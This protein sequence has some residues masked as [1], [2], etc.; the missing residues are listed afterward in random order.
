[1]ATFGA[2]LRP[3]GQLE[4]GVEPAEL[5]RALGEAETVGWLD[6]EAPTAEQIHELEGLFGFHPLALEDAQHADTR[7]KIEE[8]DTFLFVVT[9]GVDHGT[10]ASA[11]DLIP[12]YA[13]L[14]RRV[15]VTIHD[16][17]LRS[18]TTAME[19]L[20]KHPE[21]L[22]H[23]PDRLLHHLLDHIVDYF[24]PLLEELEDRV[25]RL[26]DR[27]FE[28]PDQ[29]LLQEIFQARRE[30][31]ALRRSIG[32]LR[33]VVTNLMSGVPYVDADL[34]PFFR[35]VYDHV[36][37]ILEELDA[38]RDLLAGLLES[39]LSQI[40]NRMNQVMKQLALV[41]TVGIPFTIVTSFFGMNFEIMPWLKEPW[42][43]LAAVITMVSLSATLFVVC[44][45][46]RWL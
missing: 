1:V 30:V 25:D 43:V 40:S 35:D 29:T 32:P 31:A 19:R 20:R 18:V 38:N 27:V 42:G 44:R 11:L 12:L 17:P 33:E 3:G 13:L 28:A 8:Y 16:R 5:A 22:R 10:E 4:E 7:P 39:Y 36:L 6:L 26:E 14:D 21:M 23:G 34:R 9:R 46:R 15:I 45:L 2:V 41:A 24:F 37:R